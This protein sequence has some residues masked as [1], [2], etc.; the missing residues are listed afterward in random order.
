[1]Q[2]P[3]SMMMLSYGAAGPAVKLLQQYLNLLPSQLLQLVEDG[4]FGSK[5]RA[6][7]H[8][9]QSANALAP[10]A[11]VGP[12]TWDAILAALGGPD[13]WLLRFRI[14]QAADVDATP[15]DVSAKLSAGKDSSDPQRRQLRM[16]HAKLLKYF[17]TSWPAPGSPNRSAVSEDAIKYFARVGGADQVGRLEPLPHWCGIF[18]LWAIKAA[19]ANVGTWRGGFGIGSVPGF[20]QIHAPL[21]GDVG[22]V[23]QPFQHHFIIR[24]LW[25]EGGNVQID[26]I[27]GNSPPSSNFSF[28][29]RNLKEVNA[30][31]SIF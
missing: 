29:R 12:L 16:G 3:K 28:K 27:E 20:H 22:Y 14:I 31:Y 25:P 2:T 6:R 24:W 13:Q 7:V 17:R 21:P 9:F 15:R 5:T 26:T 11:V 8:E 30:W 1:M 23:D 18:A 4:V 19:G 10:D